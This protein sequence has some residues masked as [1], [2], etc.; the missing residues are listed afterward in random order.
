MSTNLLQIAKNALIAHRAA[1]Q[2]IGHNVANAETPG[3][4]RQRPILEPLPGAGQGLVEGTGAGQGVTIAEV[5]Q[6][7]NEFLGLQLDQQT[8][9]LGREATLLDGLQRAEGLL[10]DLQGGGVAGALA[11]FFNAWSDLSTMPSSVTA[12]TNVLQRAEALCDA[13][14]RRQEN[15]FSLRQNIDL[16]L[17]DKV[18]QINRLATEVAELNEKVGASAS[19]A[20][21]NDLMSQ[22]EQAIRQLAKLCGAQAIKQDQG[23]MDV[24]VGGMRLVQHSQVIELALDNDPAQPGFHRVVFAGSSNEIPLGGE[25]AGMIETRDTYIV[26]YRQQMDDLAKTLADEVNAIHQAGYDLDGNTGLDFFSYNAGAA[27]S[28]LQL[29]ADVAGK[30][31]GI[32]AAV[33][34][35]TEGDGQNAVLINDLRYSKVASSGSYTLEEYNADI[36]GIIGGD[37]SRSQAAFNSR[38]RLVNNLDLN[39]QALAGVSLDEE[40]IELIRYQQT[41]MAASKMV[42]MAVQMMDAILELAH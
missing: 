15:L 28:T 12:R 30:P 40:A 22:R 21:R 6:L 11:D 4:V 14:T 27:A 17:D 7:R 5:Q 9:L 33:T 42:T 8:A 20:V 34:T 32:A 10:M 16:Q 31:R 38:D 3:Y 1:I 29:A 36:V 26:S 2:I 25:L 23:S 19:P 18:Q 41:Y 37:I 39:Y 13:I 35:N 24:V